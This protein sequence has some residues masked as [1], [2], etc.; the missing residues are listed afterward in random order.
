MP[1]EGSWTPWSASAASRPGCGTSGSP[2]GRRSRRCRVEANQ[3]Y[4]TYVDLRGADLFDA[5][6]YVGSQVAST[7]VAGG[8]PE[9]VVPA[10]AAGLVELAEDRVVA[11]TLA[12]EGPAAGVILETFGAALVRDPEGLRRD[13][14]GGATLPAGDKLAMLTR[15]FWSQ[16]ARIVVPDGVQLDAADPA[17]AGGRACPSRALITRTLV[18]LGA[19]ASACARRGAAAVGRRQS[20][21]PPARRSRRACSPARPR[22]CWAATPRSRWPRSRTCRCARSRSSIATRRSARAPRSTGPSPSSAA[23][24]VRSRVDNRLVGDRASVEQVEIVF[25]IEDQLFDLTSYT[26]HLGRDTTGNLLS[27]GVLVD[28]ARSYMKGLITIEKTR[29]R[30]RLVPRRVRDEPLEGRPGGRDPVARDRPAR[31]PPRGPLVRRSAR[32]TRTSSSTSRAAA[33]R[34]TRPAS[35]SSSASSSRSWPACRSRRPATG[36]G[37]CSRRSGP[38]GAASVAGGRRPP[39]RCAGS[40]SSALDDVPE[41]TLQM[42][43]VDGTD[44]VVVVHT[45]GVIRAFQGIC[46]HEYFELDKGFLTGGG[47]PLPDG[48]RA[49]R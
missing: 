28:R 25:G 1:I 12:A 13:L 31:L 48:R 18:S 24:L 47:S 6:P 8:A 4:T 44:Q 27:K 9:A 29:R 23:R 40:T 32:S 2:R 17:S 21:A 19:G 30:H 38:P 10:G 7:A 26:R 36:F 15:G 5:R 20:P 35:S 49:A 42:A 3:L 14:E 37:R 16:G 46:T 11:M 34:P 45:D 33:S 41:G 43:Y 22:S 39:T